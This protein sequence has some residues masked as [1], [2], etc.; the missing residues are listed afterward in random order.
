MSRTVKVK[1]RRRTQ[2]VRDY[3]DTMASRVWSVKMLPNGSLGAT[4]PRK[5]CGGK[6]V[7]N[8]DQLKQSRRYLSVGYMICP[9]CERMTPLPKEVK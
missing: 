5:P 4:C 3:S 9:Y 7:V 2:E 6:V 1:K 8:P